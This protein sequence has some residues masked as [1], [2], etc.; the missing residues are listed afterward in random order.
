MDLNRSKETTL[1]KQKHRAN[2]DS[3]LRILGMTA[4]RTAV[5]A[6]IAIGNACASANLDGTWR[7]VSVGSKPVSQLPP[8]QV[9]YLT[10]SG[11]SV[12][13]FDGCNSFSGRIDQPGNISATRRGC[14][15]GVIKLPLDLGDLPSHLQSGTVEKNFLSVP[16]RGQFPASMFEHSK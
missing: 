16:A 5:V 14:P 8:E 9:P 6:A 1:P 7:L 10:I 12:E 2:R 11:T 4:C 3:A 13:G 15:E